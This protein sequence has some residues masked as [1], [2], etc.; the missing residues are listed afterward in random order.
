MPVRV[1]RLSCWCFCLSSAAGSFGLPSCDARLCLP[2]RRSNGAARVIFRRRAH[3]P[4]LHRE[5]K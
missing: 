5:A 2:A 4:P 3:G 1:I